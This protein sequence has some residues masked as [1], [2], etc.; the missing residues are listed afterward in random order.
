[1]GD[2]RYKMMETKEL[3]QLAMDIIDNKVF[4]TW[5]LKDPEKEL[6]MVFMIYLFFDEKDRKEMIKQEIV[7]FYEYYNKAC[8]MSV[9]GMPT[10]LSCRNINKND[11]N[12]VIKYVKQYERTKN[13]FLDEKTKNITE[14]NQINL[15]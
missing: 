9:N 4:G 15:F 2:I 1:M 11:W 10:F 5:N 13:K 14:E 8:P 12:E 6:P 7:H 3:K